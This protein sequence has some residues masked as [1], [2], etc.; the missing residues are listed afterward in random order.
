MASSWKLP[1]QGRNEA[2]GDIPAYEK[3]LL[4]YQTY[5]DNLA[6]DK[7]N[8][9][10][11]KLGKAATIAVLG[12]CAWANRLE[13]NQETKMVFGW[14]GGSDKGEAREENNLNK[15]TNKSEVFV[16]GNGFRIDRSDYLGF[17]PNFTPT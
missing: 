8:A 10:L 16:W 12:G 3:N 13:Y 7:M 6:I 15:K 14:L 9:T 2:N 17:Y 1:V 5:R 4:D 11:K